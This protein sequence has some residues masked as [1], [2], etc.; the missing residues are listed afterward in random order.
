M[1]RKCIIIVTFIY[2]ILLFIKF[3]CKLFH[4][5]HKKGNIVHPIL[6]VRTLMTR[7]FKIS[8]Q[9]VPHECAL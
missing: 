8:D 2:H 3:L 4:E 7:D 6:L 9:S 1:W 5:V